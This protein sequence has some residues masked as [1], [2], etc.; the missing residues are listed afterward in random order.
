MDLFPRGALNDR[1][2]EACHRHSSAAY[3]ITQE[4]RQNTPSSQI[5]SYYI[6]VVWMQMHVIGPMAFHSFQPPGSFQA[7]GER[8]VCLPSLQ[9][10]C[11]RNGTTCLL[12]LFI[13]RTIAL[14][15]QV[16]RG[17]IDANG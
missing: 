14:L 6:S 15:A 7:P 8:Y 1:Q 5:R 4:A 10:P 3:F 9:M 16:F 17:H 12:T 11:T 13:S 2:I